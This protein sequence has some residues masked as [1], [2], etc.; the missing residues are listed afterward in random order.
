MEYLDGENLEQRL[1]KGPLSVEQTS[2]YAAQIAEALA[3]A[4]KA[5][6]AHRDLKP[7]NVMLTK[8]GQSLAPESRVDNDSLRSLFKL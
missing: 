2:R 4:H 7:S 8:N 5:G 1:K 6:I 3:H